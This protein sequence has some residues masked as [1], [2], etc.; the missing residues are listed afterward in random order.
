MSSTRF[1][2]ARRQ[3]LCICSACARAC[4]AYRDG[5]VFFFFCYFARQKLYRRHTCS[6]VDLLFVDDLEPS[7]LYLWLF[8]RLFFLFP[9]LG[10]RFFAITLLLLLFSNIRMYTYTDVVRELTGRA[11]GDGERSEPGPRRSCHTLVSSSRCTRRAPREWI[12]LGAYFFFLLCKHVPISKKV[13]STLPLITLVPVQH[14]QRIR[15]WTQIE[16]MIMPILPYISIPVFTFV[17]Y[18]I[19]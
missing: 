13:R 9:P 3:A 19:F 6:D 11:G 4:G 16:I 18:I 1:W 10:R 5:F 12:Q 17:V 15:V 7:R 2:T 14:A 8:R